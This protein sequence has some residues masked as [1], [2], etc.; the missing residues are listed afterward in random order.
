[1]ILGRA[2]LKQPALLLAMSNKS[3]DNNCEKNPS[4]EHALNVL[5]IARARVGDAIHGMYATVSDEQNGP[6]HQ[7]HSPRHSRHHPNVTH[8]TGVS[9]WL[10]PG[11]KGIHA[12]TPEMP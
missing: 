2:E 1:M 10:V 12:Q 9:V 7:L 8:E 5:S 6:S 3:Q 11:G 4:S